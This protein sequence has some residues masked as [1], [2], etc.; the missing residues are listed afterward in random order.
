MFH[1][2]CAADLVAVI[3]SILHNCQYSSSTEGAI[4]KTLCSAAVATSASGEVG[5]LKSLP[6]QYS[7]FYSGFTQEDASECLFML[8]DI[9]NQ[10]TI[11]VPL[12]VNSHTSTLCGVSL[13]DS[14]LLFVLKNITYVTH[15][16]YIHLHLNIVILLTL[17]L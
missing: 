10:G 6:A 11:G 1:E 5:K 14:L 8:L 13:T 3:R 9:I 17:P 15:V 12:V 2:C 7:S 4:A 16:N